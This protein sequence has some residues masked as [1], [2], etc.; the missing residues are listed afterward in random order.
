MFLS[1]AKFF[2]VDYKKVRG[3][4]V[5]SVRLSVC[6]SVRN[7]NFN[8]G[9]LGLFLTDWAERHWALRHRWGIKILSEKFCADPTTGRLPSGPP[10]AAPPK[11]LKMP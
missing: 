4:L 2:A 7:T 3:R 5:A 6:P 11:T 10:P 8:I 9:F 1:T